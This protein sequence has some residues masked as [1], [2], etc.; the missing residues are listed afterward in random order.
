[1]LGGLLS[2]HLR[3]SFTTRLLYTLLPNSWYAKNDASLLAL[4]TALATDL[5]QL[6]TS[7]VTVEASCLHLGKELAVWV[8]VPFASG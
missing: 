2:E 3:H 8:C 6:F 7:G 4:H 1:M 5:A